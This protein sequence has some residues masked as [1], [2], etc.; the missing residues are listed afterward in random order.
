[1][2]GV[3]L[4]YPSDSRVTDGAT[5]V[6]SMLAYNG[7]PILPHMACHYVVHTLPMNV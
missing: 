4:D 6:P 3:A 7:N 1:M 2:K 5:I